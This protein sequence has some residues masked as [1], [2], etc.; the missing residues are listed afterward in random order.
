MKPYTITFEERPQYLYV[1]VEGENDSYEISR[2]FWTEIV[3]YLKGKEYEK[4]LV[5]ER[6][7]ETVSTEDVYRLVTEFPQMGLT[8]LKI[9]FVDE[10]LDRY[11]IN[12]FGEIVALN[13]DLNGKIFN[14]V[15]RAEGWLLEDERDTEVEY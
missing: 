15:D 8:G 7:E 4:V 12:Q 1:L 6:L 14:D 9:A 13:L 3:D 5:V 10:V 2:Q 11:T